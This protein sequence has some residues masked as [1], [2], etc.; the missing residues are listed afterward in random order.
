MIELPPLPKQPFFRKMLTPL[1]EYLQQSRIVPGKN[2]RY[3]ETGAGGI[4]LEGEAGGKVSALDPCAFGRAIAGATSGKKTL[5]AGQIHANGIHTP[6]G[7]DGG[8]E[9][10]PTDGNYIWA[11]VNIEADQD[12]DDLLT[13]D[14]TPTGATLATGSS[15]PDDHTFTNVA[16][17]GKAYAPLGLWVG[18]SFVAYGCGDVTFKFCRNN[19]I[20]GTASFYRG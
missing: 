9:F 1:W 5:S 8:T 7:G 2:I 14:W 12:D 10:T 3:T 18:T 11:E 16:P 4:L 15:V 19:S 17:S 13:G 20:S 6:E